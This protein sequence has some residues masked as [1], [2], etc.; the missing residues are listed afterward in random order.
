MT[1]DEPRCIHRHSIKTH[2][3]CFRKGLVKRADWY[4]EKSIAY[5]DIEV[6]DLKANFGHMLT[7]CLKY[8]DDPK[9][10]SGVITKEELFNYQFDKRIIQEVIEELKNVDILVTYFGRGFDVPFLRTRALY[11]DLEFP[12]YG[13]LVHWDLYYHVKR[14]LKVHRKSL[15]VVTNFF[16]ISGK[17]H[18]D[19]EVWVRAK[20][21]DPKALKEVLYHN[22]QDVIILEKLHNKLGVFSKWIRSSI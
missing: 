7:W 4:K 9:I 15:D 11:Y 5:F 16:G 14:H 10:R 22:E 12:H 21:G 13:S 8:K 6:S 1:I 20:Y 2:P 3:N 18:I 19:W 17:T